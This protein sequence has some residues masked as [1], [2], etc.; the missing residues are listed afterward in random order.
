[1]QKIIITIEQDDTHILPAIQLAGALGETEDQ[2][3]ADQK[4]EQE[5]QPKHITKEQNERYNLASDLA[6]VCEYMDDADVMKI[7]VIV[8]KCNTRKKKGEA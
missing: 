4:E 6:N 8:D 7:K 2:I 3:T 5:E 1:M